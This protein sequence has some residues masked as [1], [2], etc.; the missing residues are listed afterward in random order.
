MQAAQLLSNSVRLYDTDLKGFGA[1]AHKSGGASYFIE[2]RLAPHYSFKTGVVFPSGLGGDQALTKVIREKNNR[3]MFAVTFNPK[4]PSIS[5]IIT[6]HWRTMT[7]DKKLSNTFKQPPMVAFK[8]P[9]NLQKIL[10]HAK[11]PPATASLRDHPKRDKFGLKKCNRPCP[12]DIHV[13]PSKSVTSTHTGEKH[14]LTGEFNCLTKGVIYITTCAKCKKQYIGQT[15]RS[16]HE[17]IREHMYDIKKGTKTSGIHYS[18]KGHSH[19]DFQVQVIEKVTPN[20]DHY[21][22]EREEFWIKKFATKIPF[23]LNIQD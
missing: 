14:M 23:G 3:V 1:T 9:P 11:L 20:T 16:L 22:L 7:R 8:Q 12:I 13:I 19:W 6:K 4:L 18:L 17:R 2:Y 21:R 15:G 10:C 5:K